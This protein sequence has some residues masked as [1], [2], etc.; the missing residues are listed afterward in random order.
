LNNFDFDRLNNN[1]HENDYSK[2]LNLEELDK[3]IQE[4]FIDV[5]IGQPQDETNS[6]NN[7]G[8]FSNNKKCLNIQNLG[9]PDNSKLIKNEDVFSLR[10]S[11]CIMNVTNNLDFEIKILIAIIKNYIEERKNYK[12]ILNHAKKLF[13][14]FLKKYLDIE[15]IPKNN[16][17]YSLLLETKK[18]QFEE[19][20]S[21]NTKE[22]GKPGK[23]KKGGNSINFQPNQKSKNDSINSK[24][25]VINSEVYLEILEIFKVIFSNYDDSKD[26]SFFRRYI[27]GVYEE[28]GKFFDDS[29][30]H[31]KIK[32]RNIEIN[33]KL[34]DYRDIVKYRSELMKIMNNM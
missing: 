34:N 3:K 29:V 19:L 30:S 24:H 4:I 17:E 28:L 6:E 23:A 9:M 31:N 16:Y 26:T 10:I 12:L 11:R 20:I 8:I 14:L 21:K 5:L 32:F 27:I 1:T 13:G 22:Q 7:C 33:I 25:K 2:N 15:E 18:A